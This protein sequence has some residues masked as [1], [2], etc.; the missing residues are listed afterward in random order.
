MEEDEAVAS[1]ISVAQGQRPLL[2]KSPAS[3]VRFFC[4]VQDCTLSF[5]YLYR[6]YSVLV[7]LTRLKCIQ[8][9]TRLRS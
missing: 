1:I 3:Q 4:T 7:I 8:I 5:V 2:S 6:M 9:E